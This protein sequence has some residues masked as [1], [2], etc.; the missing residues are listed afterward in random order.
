MTKI[1]VFTVNDQRPDEAWEGNEVKEK[2]AIAKVKDAH[3]NRKEKI[4]WRKAFALFGY[5]T[6]LSLEEATDLYERN[7]EKREDELNEIIY[8]KK[9]SLPWWYLLLSPLGSISGFVVVYLGFVVWHRENVYV[10]TDTW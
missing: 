7:K 4:R 1:D 2:D 8:D 10:H 6:D 9:Y 5:T 3:E